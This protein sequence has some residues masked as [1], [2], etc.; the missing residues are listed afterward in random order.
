MVPQFGGN[1]NRLLSEDRWSRVY[2]VDEVSRIYE[3]KFATDGI[4]ISLQELEREWEIWTESERLSFAKAYAYKSS[5][6]LDDGKV[7]DYLMERGSE[8]IWQSIAGCLPR[9]PDRMRARAFLLERLR[10]GS[11]TVANFAQVLVFF[12][13]SEVIFELRRFHDRAVAEIMSRERGE[14]VDLI[15]S[16]LYSCS[17][18]R[19]LQGSSVYDEEIERFRAY[20]NRIVRDIVAVLLKSTDSA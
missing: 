13:D 6:G 11:K 4:V 1:I 2:E 16:F 10:S 12:G 19:K 3:S 15:L 20:P 14:D 8:L 5:F 9:H 18:L 7:L 17:S